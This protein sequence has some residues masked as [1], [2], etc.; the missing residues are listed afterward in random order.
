MIWLD[1]TS[2]LLAG[3]E[4]RYEEERREEGQER[5]ERARVRGEGRRGEVGFN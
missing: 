2:I 3:M 1:P 4:R 5:Q